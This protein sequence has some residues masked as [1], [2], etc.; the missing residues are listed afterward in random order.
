MLPF[1]LPGYNHVIII[2]HHN[3]IHHSPNFHH[4]LKGYLVGLVYTRTYQHDSLTSDSIRMRQRNA[5][6]EKN[7]LEID[8]LTRITHIHK[9]KSDG[10]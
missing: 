5:N 4:I 10:T 9:P 2:S 3:I 1:N 8:Q 7:E 6:P